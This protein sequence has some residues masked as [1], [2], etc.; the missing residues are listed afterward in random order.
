MIVPISP[1]FHSLYGSSR[2]LS[3]GMN[4]MPCRRKRSLIQSRSLLEVPASMVLE[5]P[6]LQKPQI[7]LTASTRGLLSSA[8][9]TVISGLVAATQ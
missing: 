2:L 1:R 7:T 4:E 9:R 3:E 5:K 6:K 8:I